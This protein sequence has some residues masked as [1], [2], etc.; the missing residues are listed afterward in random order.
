[1]RL[2]YVADRVHAHLVAAISVLAF[3]VRSARRR[4][5]RRTADTSS[6]GTPW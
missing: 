6:A 5:R 2:H 3:L 4:A 1:M